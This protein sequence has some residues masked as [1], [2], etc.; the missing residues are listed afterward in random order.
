ME[1]HTPSPWGFGNGREGERLIL[2]DN[3]EGN[4][5]CNVQIHQ[6][7]RHMGR[8]D[9]EEREANAKLIAAAPD[10]LKELKEIHAGLLEMEG[11]EIPFRAAIKLNGARISKLIL[12]AGG[13]V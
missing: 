5:V 6:T 2:G 4:Y 7:P 3:G 1:E 9:E 10:L 12:A 11:A 8:W 13:S